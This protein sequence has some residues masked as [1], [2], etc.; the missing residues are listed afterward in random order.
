VEDQ[1]QVDVPVG[2]VQADPSHDHDHD[3]DHDHGD[4]RI[5]STSTRD[6]ASLLLSALPQDSTSSSSSSESE[7]DTEGKPLVVPG[8]G[9]RP[10]G[11]RVAPL[12]V[13][14]ESSKGRKARKG[15]PV[16]PPRDGSGKLGSS[17]SGAGSGPVPHLATV[18]MPTAQSSGGPA[19]ARS[20]QS[21]SRVVSFVS[22]SC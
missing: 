9:R 7:S 6:V 8:S 3:H 17:A 2:T 5:S 11:S 20:V 15:N 13:A 1:G 19:T 22:V 12:D 21:E 10:S 18:P 14:I 16:L 4:K